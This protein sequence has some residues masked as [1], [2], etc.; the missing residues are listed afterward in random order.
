MHQTMLKSSRNKW[1][2]LGEGMYFWQNNYERAIHYAK[3]PPPKVKI[4]KPAVLG[5]VFSLGNCLDLSDK[6]FIDLIQLS[7]ES[8]KR[9]ALSEGTTLPANKNSSGQEN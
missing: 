3:N 7:Y 2:W 1:D 8:L 5:A 9:S 4:A 6:R